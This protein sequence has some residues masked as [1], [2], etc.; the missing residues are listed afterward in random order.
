[1]D[2][3]LSKIIIEYM[4]SKNEYH[5][6]QNIID[7]L[8]KNI[9]YAKSQIEKS[10]ISKRLRINEFETKIAELSKSK[11]NDEIIK[12]YRKALEEFDIY[13][14]QL[15][16]LYRDGYPK[17]FDFRII[18]IVP[19]KIFNLSNFKNIHEM[20]NEI[21]TM[22]KIVINNTIKLNETIGQIIYSYIIKLDTSDNINF[23]YNNLHVLFDK[24][25]DVCM[26]MSPEYAKLQENKIIIPKQLKSKY[27]IYVSNLI[28]N[29][30][31]Y[32]FLSPNDIGVI[33]DPNKIFHNCLI[34]RNFI[35]NL[36][37]YLKTK[38][39]PEKHVL[40]SKDNSWISLPIYVKL[41]EDNIKKYNS[42]STIQEQ[43]NIHNKDI[44]LDIL[45]IIKN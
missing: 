42:T 5:H 22:N 14:S 1:M 38:Y 35:D 25:D 3:D 21:D 36:I 41:L 37:K 23:E 31:S 39:K 20:N 32:Y 34:L 45:K 18:P 11:A 8:Q 2:N 7:N 43:K 16:R 40:K 9:T 4:H 10:I 26:N 12:N 17:E 44:Y 13:E 6:K 19:K 29:T 30:L 33:A 27:Q 28:V 15:K 24:F